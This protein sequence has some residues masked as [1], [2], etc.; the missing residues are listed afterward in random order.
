MK[1]QAS[2]LEMER[3]NYTET[4]GQRLV[5][6]YSLLDRVI[7]PEDYVI[8]QE[9]VNDRLRAFEKEFGK[10]IVIADAKV[11]PVFQDSKM[12]RYASNREE[13]GVVEEYESRPIG[14][15]AILTIDFEKI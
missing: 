12:I 8:L 2:T 1:N 5:L 7:L 6:E 10:K 3:E 4:S 14:L 9:R 13:P 11:N 15:Q